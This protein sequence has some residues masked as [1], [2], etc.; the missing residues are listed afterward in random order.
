MITI[1]TKH[2]DNSTL[3]FLATECEYSVELSVMPDGA[4]NSALCEGKEAGKIA[5]DIIDREKL[6]A[7]SDHPFPNTYNSIVRYCAPVINTI[8]L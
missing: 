8:G 7:D 4:V 2:D 1:M 3:D 6:L 5:L